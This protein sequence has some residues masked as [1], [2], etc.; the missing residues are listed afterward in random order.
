MTGN[1]EGAQMIVDT[2]LVV[3]EVAI[4]DRNRYLLATAIERN[5]LFNLQIGQLL[6][7]IRKEQL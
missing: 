1:R 7:P 5:G 6:T 4:Y 2:Y 3:D